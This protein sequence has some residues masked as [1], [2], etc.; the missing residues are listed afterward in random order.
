MKKHLGEEYRVQ[1]PGGKLEKLPGTRVAGAWTVGA[2]SWA[3]F[4]VCC[5]RPPD[6]LGCRLST[7]SLQ[8]TLPPGA[9]EKMQ[10]LGSSAEILIHR[11]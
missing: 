6:P 3:A 1:G 4:E 9:L 8:G 10:R 2:D 11:V 5:D 7:F